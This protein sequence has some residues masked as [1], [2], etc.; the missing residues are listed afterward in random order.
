MYH[1]VGT[2][3]TENDQEKTWTGKG[4]MPKTIAAA[5]SAGRTLEEFPI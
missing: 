1:I 4:R 5:V 3:Y 2:H